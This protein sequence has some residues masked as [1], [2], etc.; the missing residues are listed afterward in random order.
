MA[1]N[2]LSETQTEIIRTEQSLDG[3]DVVAT[4]PRK[5]VEDRH[6]FCF[7]LF[8][9]FYY[10]YVCRCKPITNDDI[11]ECAK[12]DKVSYNIQRSGQRWLKEQEEYLKTRTEWGLSEHPPNEKP[13]KRP[14]IFTYI[15]FQ[16]SK[17]SL[18]VNIVWYLVSNAPYLI[19]PLIMKLLLQ[20]IANKETNGIFPFASGLV[21]IVIPYIQGLADG[22]C[23]RLFYH[24]TLSVRGML[25]AFIFDKTLK[26]NLN[27]QGEVDSGRLLSLITADTRNVGDDYWQIYYLLLLPLHVV[28][29]LV[30][31]LIDF[32]ATAL[33]SIAVWI[34]L[35]P[36]S[37]ISTVMM[38]VATQKY[39][40]SNDDRNTIINETLQGIRVVKYSGLEDVFI[41][42]IENKRIMQVK[43]SVEMVTWL[44]ISNAI[45][46]SIPASVNISVIFLLVATRGLDESEFA[47]FVMP[48]LGFLTLMTREATML[49]YYIQ[50]TQTTAISAGRIRDFLLLPEMKIEERAPPSDASLSITIE[51]GEFKWGEAPE[52]PLTEEEQAELDEKKKEEEKEVKQNKARTA[53]VDQTEM[54]VESPTMSPKPSNTPSTSPS[55]SSK[56]PHVSVLTDMC[57]QIPTGSL[58]MVVGGVGSGKSSLAA[59][60]TGDV[61]RVNGTVCIRGS[62]AFCPQI[63][64]INNS[65]VRSNIVFGMPFDEAKYADVV[66]VCALEKDLQMLAAGDQTAIGEKGVNLSGGQKARIQLAR[67][68]YSDRDIVVLD[69]PLSAVDAHAGRFLIDECILGRLKGKTVVLMTNQ[70]Q[71]LD[72]ADK[73][74]ALKDGRIVGQGR[75]EELRE[76]GINFDEFIIQSE[77]KDKK[78]RKEKKVDIQNEEVKQDSTSVTTQEEEQVKKLNPTLPPQE[79][80]ETTS[81][82]AILLAN[83]EENDSDST[84]QSSST[85][86]PTLSN[87]VSPFDDKEKAEK[88]ARQMMTEEEQS[89]GAISFKTYFQLI[90]TMMP[91]WL[92]PF[93]LLFGIIVESVTLF[94]SYW[95]GVVPEPTLFVPLT[96]HWK[97]GIYGLLTILAL[98]FL[99]LYACTVGCSTHRSNRIIHEKLLR[100]V[101]HCPVSFFD[102]TPL[103][104]VINR[105]GGD[106]AQTDTN[107]VDVLYD[108]YLLVVGFVGQIVIIAISTPS[109]LAIGLP[110]LLLFGIVLVLYS[111]AARD[112]Q[113]LDSIS[114]SPVVSIFS[115]VINGAG[116]STIRAFRQEDRWKRR[117]EEK[118]DDWTV[119]TLLY[120]EGKNWGTTYTSL[121]SMIYVVGVVVIGWFFMTAP[122]LSVALTSSLNFNMLVIIL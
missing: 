104:R 57:L 33:I 41:D 8:F 109:F 69:D 35:I 79:D 121:I 18:G 16:V 64:W 44:Y 100:H 11:F 2:E 7:N 42:R 81:A 19:M 90:A 3:S 28:V 112:L 99:F 122:Q 88:A 84:N 27:T 101:M 118:V 47:V 59:A 93:T 92:L 20:D 23:Y 114:C 22:V 37:M 46:R 54:A 25:C 77:E 53:T 43:A 68:V 36:I 89:T 108:V 103:G 119:R 76:Q 30:F 86:S 5:N 13:P 80:T 106:I 87:A 17:K 9:F 72:R 83:A 66:R 61:E 15:L 26:L 85:P 4:K 29:P 75:Y 52:V 111:R 73:V 39:L 116:L 31:V 78:E 74:V 51:G 1:D 21:Q 120:W 49:P 6:N 105:F 63:A 56:K 32:G 40:E 70:I 117:F 12:K 110:V 58:T 91:V 102:T 65:T 45:I 50:S 94:Q 62:I 14:S 55:P 113:R 34:V 98:I 82:S 10:P 97:L 48:N 60:I 95:L 67:A 115:E 24:R 71:F 96:F 38:G 107:L